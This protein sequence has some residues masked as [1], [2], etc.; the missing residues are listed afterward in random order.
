MNREIVRVQPQTF[1]TVI[2]HRTDVGRLELV[3]SYDLLLHLVQGV[4]VVGNLHADNV[5]RSVK[6]VGMLVES[7]DGGALVR[8]VGAQSL[9]HAE[10]VVKGMREHVHLGVAPGHVLTVHPDDPFPVLHSH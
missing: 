10:P 6:P 4:F 1:G 3:L 5:G 8:A 7:E 9:E 2:D